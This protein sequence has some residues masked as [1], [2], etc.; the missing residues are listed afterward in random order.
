MKIQIKVVLIILVFSGSIYAQDAGIIFPRAFAFAVDDMGWN[1]GNDDGDIDGKG[2]YR[3]GIDRKMDIHDYEAIVAV[4]K[5]VGVRIQGLFVMAEMDRENILA[6]YPSTTWQGSNWD[7]SK[8][9]CK[10]QIDIMNYV[11]D[12]AAYLEFGLHGVGHERWING[13]KKR[14]EWYCL[15]DD[16]PWPEDS[17]KKDI[18]CFKNIMS[19]YGLSTEEG[20]SFPES[21]V[22][23]AYG[24]Y[25]NPEGEYSTGSV[26][27]EAGVKY[28]NTLFDEIRELNPP[29]EPNGG[30]FDNGVLVVNRINYGN[31]WYALSSLPTIDIAEQESDIIESHW[32]NWLAQDAFLQKALTNK[33]I[34]YYKMVQAT[35]NRYIAKNTAQFFSQWLY[36][37]YTQVN[38]SKD[39]QVEIDNRNMPAEYYKH[40]LLGNMVL[41]V[42]LDKGQHVSMAT[43]NNG[44][45]ASYFE[46]AGYGFLYLPRLDQGLY[47]LNYKLSDHTMPF[48]VFNDGT[49]NVYRVTESKN[50]KSLDVKVYGSQEIKIFCS[51]PRSVESEN[52]NLKIVGTNYNKDTG[53]LAIRV[54]AH[55]IQG[56][57]GLLNLNY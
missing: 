9:I 12:N 13:Q 55:N 49:Y 17:V 47:I 54:N 40:N 51:D 11:K 3:I 36:K 57:E 23:C 19:Q 30:G 29:A 41:K 25:W 4:G 20:H 37:K 26:M 50:L 34:E 45:V 46:E 42:R 24:Y 14:A 16:H 53:M 15:Q 31:E 1:I 52:T 27:S 8:N 39:G 6:K 33:W 56:E 7:N 44:P 48:T 21:F 35:P 18:Q 10:E 5:V 38:E 28:V 2:P 22:P 32:S 43:L